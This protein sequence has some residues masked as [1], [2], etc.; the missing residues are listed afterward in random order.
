MRFKRA[1]LIARV[2]TAIA[3]QR[4]AV[5]ERNAEAAAEYEKKLAAYTAETWEPW[6]QL[7]DTIRVRLR[8]GKPMVDADIPRRLRNGFRS[9]HIDTWSSAPP[10]RQVADTSVL[11]QL[12]VLLQAAT[13]EEV[14]LASL[15][16]MG[17]RTAALFA[18][19]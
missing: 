6:K 5:D 3:V 17:F 1:D 13:D 11:E 12:L 2:E 18:R 7:A 10:A 15:E 14:T 9:Q 16:R 4:K 19:R 8:T